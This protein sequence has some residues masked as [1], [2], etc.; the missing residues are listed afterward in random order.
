VTGPSQVILGIDP[1]LE[2]TGYGLLAARG[3]DVTFLEAGTIEGGKAGLSLESRLRNLYLGMMSLVVEY[4]PEAVAMEQLYSH[5]A[6]PRTAILMGHARGVL[7]LAA[8]MNE[9]AVFDYPSTQVKASL[10]GSG[11]AS[12]LQMQ[13]AVRQAL[14]LKSE[15]E[16][17]DVADALAVALCHVYRSTGS[18]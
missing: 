6:H 12:K 4:R 5:Y 3:R 9:T 16:P 8:A 1:G 13:R 15:P 18:F 14:G 7:N 17:A 11:R 10:T 2:I